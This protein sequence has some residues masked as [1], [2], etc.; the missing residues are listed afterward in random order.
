MSIFRDVAQLLDD[1]EIKEVYQLNNAPLHCSRTNEDDITFNENIIVRNDIINEIKRLVDPNQCYENKFIVRHFKSYSTIS[2]EKNWLWFVR[3]YFSLN[4]DKAYLSFP[5]HVTGSGEINK[6]KIKSIS[7]IH[8]FY[9][10]LSLALD[11]IIDTYI[12]KH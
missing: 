3:I 9:N 6:S 11:Y 7:D 10:D 5:N 4:W 8:K 2:Y 1:A 12:F